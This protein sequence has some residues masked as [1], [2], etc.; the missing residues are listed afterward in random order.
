MSQNLE[1]IK[2]I[3]KKFGIKVKNLYFTEGKRIRVTTK[4]YIKEAEKLNAVH[5]IN[6]FRKGKALNPTSAIV[7]VFGHKAKNRVKL[8]YEELK[9]FLEK[10]EIEKNLKEN[11]YVLIEFCNKTVALGFYKNQKLKCFISKEL[12]KQILEALRLRYCQK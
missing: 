8:S 12:R 7:F 2:K 6:I 5:G 3:L 10:G 11:G 9:E 4:E 1:D